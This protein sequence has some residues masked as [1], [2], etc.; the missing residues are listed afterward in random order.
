[1]S[2][3]LTA[4][5]MQINPLPL[6]I[7]DKLLSF[8]SRALGYKR[9]QYDAT[10]QKSSNEKK[11]FSNSAQV[12]STEKSTKKTPLEPIKLTKELVIQYLQSAIPR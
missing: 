11:A 4:I 9:Y 5:N 7:T 6:I 8:W 1:M 12:T 10:A 2:K 3:I